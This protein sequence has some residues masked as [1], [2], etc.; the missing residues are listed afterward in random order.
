MACVRPAGARTAAEFDL[1]WLDTS[2]R[3]PKDI[4]AVQMTALLTHDS[5]HRSLPAMNI[6]DI[7]QDAGYS[8]LHSGASL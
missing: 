7:P 6:L 5:R 3:F 1:A 8:K 2:A 4:V